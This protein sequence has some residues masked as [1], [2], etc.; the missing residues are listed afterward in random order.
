MAE[1]KT[2]KIPYVG[3]KTGK[4]HFDFIVND[5]FFSQFDYSPIKAGNFEVQ[6]VLEKTELFMRL[7]FN[8]TGN[9]PAI[10]ERCTDTF[11]LAV[12]VSE[13]QIVKF[14]SETPKN[15][16]S[17]DEIMFIS[18]SVQELD[19]SQLLYEYIVSAIPLVIKHPEDEQGNSDC[20]EDILNV[21][22]SNRTTTEVPPTSELWNKL[23]DI[24]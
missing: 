21:L 24:L 16:E 11:D 17:E 2:F 19:I 13:Q 6:L 22:N 1:L 15:A 4:H 7:D 12:N 20:N 14:V 9:M 10:C 18:P 5:A 3:L 8:I 23:K